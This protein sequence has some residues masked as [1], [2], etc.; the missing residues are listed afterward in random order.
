M[1]RI[2]LAR[3]D[4]AAALAAIYAP[5]VE[6][7]PTSFELVAPDAAQMAGRVA[8]VLARWPWLVA[9]RDGVVTGY[10]YASPFAERIA[11]QWSVTVTVYV[12]ASQQRRGVGRRLYGV[13]FDLLRRQGA[14]N[15][16]AGIT[17]PNDASVGLHRALGFEP[18]ALYPRVGFK[19]GRWHDVGW[20]GLALLPSGASEPE[21]PLPLP[22][23]LSSGRLAD[24]L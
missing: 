21:P 2:R 18:C 4:D 5:S 24:L 1:E 17:L 16:F 15:A 9:E 19:L 6:R 22:A 3:A 8:D 20:Y 7:A 12:D 14:C 13:L 23:L 11:Y 10:A